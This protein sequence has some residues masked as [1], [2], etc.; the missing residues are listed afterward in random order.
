MNAGPSSVSPR[1]MS[2]LEVMNQSLERLDK[3]ALPSPRP[4]APAGT[5]GLP[6]VGGGVAAAGA[7]PSRLSSSRPFFRTAT[8]MAALPHM[9]SE[10]GAGGAGAV[11][12]AAATAGAAMTSPLD[13]DVGQKIRRMKEE[14][15]LLSKS[16]KSFLDESSFVSNAGGGEEGER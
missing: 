2:M 16:L 15:V 1:N 7:A 14:N 12:A 8:S 6:A 3:V 9:E 10:E 13:R 5:K 4:P 11:A